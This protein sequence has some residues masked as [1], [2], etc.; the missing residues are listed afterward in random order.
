VKALL[1]PLLFALLSPAAFAAE[2]AA[3]RET[4]APK[5]ARPKRKIPFNPPMEKPEIVNPIRQ[6]F[7]SAPVS[8]Q[9][10][11]QINQ[12]NKGK[13]FE[14]PSM[15]DASL[16]KSAVGP[17]YTLIP[18][19]AF[20]YN[21]N[22]GAWVGALAPL[23]RAN[24][25]GEVEDIY[26]P[27][28]L[29]N[30]KIGETFTMNYFGYRR[31]TTQFQAVGSVATKVERAVDV[32]YR[33]IAFGENGR[34]ILGLRG[35]WGKSA[36]NRF[37]GLDQRTGR[38]VESIY[39]MGDSNVRLQGGVNLPHKTA[40][41]LQQR[42]RFVSVEDG[43]TST[44]PQTLNLYRGTP[45]L[46]GA[47]I[48]G[49]SVEL[50][51]DSRDNPMTPL[52]GDLCTLTL[53]HLRDFDTSRR[54]EWGRFTVE[55][56]KYFPHAGDKAVFVLHGLADAAVGDVR[57]DV[58]FYERPTLGGENSLRGY[59]RSRFVSTTAWLINL[60]ERF[61]LVRRSVIGNV[62]EL[63]VSPF[64]D[65]GRTAQT[66]GADG[67]KFVQ[68]NPGAGLR[69]LARPNIA[70]RMDVAFGKDGANVY[71]GLDYPF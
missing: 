50:R 13:A 16:E 31:N 48:W 38:H 15:A 28:Y 33:N 49:Q 51:H 1:L 4:V 7:S 44:L 32:R 21:R 58:P 29:H 68:V 71:V 11:E 52:R 12:Q 9:R 43:V 17:G 47:A 24:T 2:A 25:K 69:M 6:D 53:E 27:M 56:R 63:E 45:G 18:L 46:A 62:I 41:L 10:L 64:V 61:S 35:D 65:I 67:F 22:E 59:G 39:T 20:V 40:V 42:L 23:F 5:K 60:E 3:P 66:F 36:F 19:P 8:T 57:R 26:A 70:G 30:D 55:G 14:Q 37:F 54:P 34:Y